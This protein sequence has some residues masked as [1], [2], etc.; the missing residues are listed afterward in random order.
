[1]KWFGALFL[2]VALAFNP[3]NVF[4]IGLNQYFFLEIIAALAI[5]ASA[6]NL[7]KHINK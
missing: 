5:F 6:L 1:L 3:V 7:S 2:F 4:V